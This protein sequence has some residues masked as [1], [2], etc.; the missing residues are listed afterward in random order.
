MENEDTKSYHS[1]SDSADF[2]DAEFSYESSHQEVL[3]VKI[4][5]DNVSELSDDNLTDDKDDFMDV[6][7]EIILKESLDNSIP[8][9]AAAASSSMPEKSEPSSIKFEDSEIQNIDSESALSFKPADKELSSAKNSEIG[10]T[11]NNNKR[12]QTI[13]EEEVSHKEKTLAEFLVD[14]D[15]YSP[16][17]PEALMD[18]YL[19]SSGF[20][21]DD[22]RM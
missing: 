14:M 3:K 7:E 9:D 5:G 12:K 17:I 8:K 19:N 2:V 20:K 21:C 10:E 22:V 4:E 18:Y 15:Q 1:D 13:L 16:I 6:D 11:P